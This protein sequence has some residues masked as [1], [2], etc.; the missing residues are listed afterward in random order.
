[1]RKTRTIIYLVAILIIGA[2]LFSFSNET[3][4]DYVECEVIKLQQQNIINGSENN[5]STE[6]RYLVVTDKETFICESSI[7]NGKFNNSD[8]FF[9][10][11]ENKKYKFKVCGIGKTFFTD[12]RNIIEVVK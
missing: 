9:R 2:I 8:I 12:Y 1:M 3:K 4:T 7:L 11:K 10:L 6:I 5:V